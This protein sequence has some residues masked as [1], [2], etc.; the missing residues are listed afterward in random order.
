MLSEWLPFRDLYISEILDQEQPPADLLCPKCQSQQ[1]LFRC[2]DCFS[3]DLLCESCCM[4]VHR[5]TPFH[6]I[7][8]WTGRFFQST[9]LNE[10]GFTLYLGHC[11]A[12]C[13]TVKGQGGDGQEVQ[14]D[15]RRCITV[16]DISGVHQLYIGWCQCNSAP[17][18]DVQLLRSRLF[19]ASIS[20]PSTAFT[21]RLLD[22]FHI[23]SVECKTSALGFFSKLRRLTNNT[24]PDSVPVGQ[25]IIFIL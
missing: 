6:S 18:V 24:S 15:A 3:R 20:M 4:I 1:G 21:F 2:K 22:Y 11:G 7:E 25:S 23:D 10:D 14:D 8:K 13:P 17:G 9:P 12:P 16:V 5:N 19:P